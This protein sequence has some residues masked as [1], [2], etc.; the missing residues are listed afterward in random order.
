MVQK[1]APAITD[2]FL[3]HFRISID[4]MMSGQDQSFV[5]SRLSDTD[6]LAD[7]ARMKVERAHPLHSRSFPFRTRLTHFWENAAVAL[8]NE[9]ERV[10]IAILS[11]VC[12]AG[13]R[14]SPY[15]REKHPEKEDDLPPS[16]PCSGVDLRYSGKVRPNTNENRRGKGYCRKNKREIKHRGGNF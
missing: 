6:F 10:T 13:V 8:T 14:S 15:R 3:S 11:K 5:D 16:R 12:P 1:A 2:S 4:K 7:T 9:P